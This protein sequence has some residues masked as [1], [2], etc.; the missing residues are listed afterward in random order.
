MM[1]IEQTPTY[2]LR[3]KTGMVGFGQK[4][5]PKIGWYVGYVESGNRV[6][7]FAMNMEV[8]KPEEGLLRQELTMGALR[9]KGIIK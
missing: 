5:S 3:A 2:T 9:K 6:W 1:I 7:L 8:N 4:V